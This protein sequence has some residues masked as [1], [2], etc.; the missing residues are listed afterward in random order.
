MAKLK[1]GPSLLG[2]RKYDVTLAPPP[3]W[4][5]NVSTLDPNDHSCITVFGDRGKELEGPCVFVGN[6]SPFG[7]LFEF[8]CSGIPGKNHVTTISTEIF[9]YVRIHPNFASRPVW[10]EKMFLCCFSLKAGRKDL[11]NRPEVLSPHPPPPPIAPFPP[12]KCF[13]WIHEIWETPCYTAKNSGVE[14]VGGGGG[15][16]ERTLALFVKSFLPAL[17]P[18]AISLPLG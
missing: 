14:G 5:R 10:C 13:I 16:G 15:W 2:F 17:L 3:H 9:K 8:L 11:T 7:G 12:E 4:R 18:P 1:V 6:S